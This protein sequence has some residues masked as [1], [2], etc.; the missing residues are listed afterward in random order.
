LALRGSTEF[1]RPVRVSFG[2]KSRVDPVSDRL[3]ELE[4]AQLVRSSQLIEY[5]LVLPLMV[6][7]SRHEGFSLQGTLNR[8]IAAISVR[9]SRSS[10][11]R[12]SPFRRSTTGDA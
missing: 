4:E 3:K 9:R 11:Q 1:N 2:L 5:P 10:Q 12:E 8:F 7:R 6:R